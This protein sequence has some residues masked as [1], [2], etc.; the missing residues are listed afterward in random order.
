MLPHGYSM[1]ICLTSR[2]SSLLWKILLLKKT[3]CWF[4]LKK[5]KIQ[6]YQK[7]QLRSL[8]I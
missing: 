4:Y 2:A 8:Q 3:G 1:D 6:I 7:F 5:S